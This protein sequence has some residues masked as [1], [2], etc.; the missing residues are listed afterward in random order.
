MEQ[1][2]IAVS[3]VLT[4]ICR[5]VVV[6]VVVVVVFIVVVVLCIYDCFTA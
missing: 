4:W 1:S 6:V 5:I 2:C 3:H